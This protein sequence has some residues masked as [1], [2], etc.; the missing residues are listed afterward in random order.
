MAISGPVIRRERCINDRVYVGEP[1]ARG[2][3][4]CAPSW[5]PVPVTIL[6]TMGT[7]NCPSDMCR[8][9]LLRFLHRQRPTPTE[10]YRV[11]AARR[12]HR[13]AFRYGVAPYRGRGHRTIAEPMNPKRTPKPVSSDPV[14]NL[15]QVR[16]LGR[17]SRWHRSS[18]G[19]R[20]DG[21]RSQQCRP[22]SA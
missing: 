1:P 18:T 17:T 6:L 16:G 10:E 19:L 20:R 12:T 13:W 14:L 21:S 7:L 22:P 8:T 3:E 5:R 9:E 2:Y 11:S 15:V 4:C